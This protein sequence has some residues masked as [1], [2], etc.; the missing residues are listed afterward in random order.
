MLVQICAT[1]GLAVALCGFGSFTG[2]LVAGI[3]IGIVVSVGGLLIDP[4]F[5]LLY[6]V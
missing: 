2:T 3:I 5:K 4:S 6:V 1:F